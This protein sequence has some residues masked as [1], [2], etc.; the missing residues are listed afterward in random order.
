MPLQPT[1]TVAALFSSSFEISLVRKIAD[2][3]MGSLYEAVLHGPRGFEKTV[4]LK[5]ILESYSNNDAFVEQFVGEAKLVADLVHQNICPGPPRPR[6][7]RR[8]KIPARR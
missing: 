3:G 8:E 2:G 7:S 1:A 6:T 4:A 5:T